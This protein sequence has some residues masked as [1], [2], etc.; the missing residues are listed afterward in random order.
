MSR[1]FAAG[2]HVEDGLAIVA[3]HAEDE[4]VGEIDAVAV[5]AGDLR[6]MQP[7]QAEPDGHAAPPLG[8]PDQVDVAEILVGVAIAAVVMP[9][10]EHRR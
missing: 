2:E 6:A 7:D 9:A 4:V 1:I 10:A 3:I 8:H 5:P